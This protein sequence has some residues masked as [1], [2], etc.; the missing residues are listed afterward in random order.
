MKAST[1][2]NQLQSQSQ[3]QQLQQVRSQ[4]QAWFNKADQVLGQLAARVKNGPRLV[5]DLTKV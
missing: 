1:L 2:A 3:T 5:D 4:Q